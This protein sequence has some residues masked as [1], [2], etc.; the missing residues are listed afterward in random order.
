M[1]LEAKIL[2][3]S[4][5]VSAGSVEDRSGAAL[6]ARLSDAGFEVVDRRVVVDGVDPVTEALRELSRDFIGLLVTTGGTGL[7]P[8]DLTPEATEAVLERQAPGLAEAMRL[9]NPLGR[10]SRAIAGTVGS[11]LIVN[12]PG[13]VKGCVECLE[14]IIDV[15]PHSL[16]LLAGGRPYPHAT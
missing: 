10:L 9:A 12:T 15:I 14:A 7:S 5:S 11:C 8:R 13:S 4:D 1:R 16:E 2:T 3:V 6:A